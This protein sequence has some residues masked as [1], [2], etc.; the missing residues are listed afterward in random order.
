MDSIDLPRR[1]ITVCAATMTAARVVCAEHALHLATLP[2]VQE[3]MAR[4]H[5]D[6][7][8]RREYHREAVELAAKHH[9]T[10]ELINWYRQH[11]AAA[12]A[13]MSHPMGE[14]EVRY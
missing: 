8:W 3:R 4:W 10:E 2:E 12:E 13:M 14:R 7:T 6:G 1:T 5:D 9:G 11:P